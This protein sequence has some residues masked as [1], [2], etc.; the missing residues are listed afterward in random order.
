MSRRQD[1]K[2]G[3]VR[4]SAEDPQI[5]GDREL[6]T[7]LAPGERPRADPTLT[8][9]E[10]E[11]VVTTELRIRLAVVGI[12]LLSGIIAYVAMTGSSGALF[13]LV[14]PALLLLAAVVGG[15]FA[16]VLAPLGAR[17]SPVWLNDNLDDSLAPIRQEREV[18]ESKGDETAGQDDALRSIN[19]S[20]NRL[21]EYYTV[22]LAQAR[23][24]FRLSAFALVSG[25]L[26]IILGVG[27]LYVDNERVEVTAISAT[28][29]IIGEF[30]G[31]AYFYVYK[32]SLAQVNYFYQNLLRQGETALALSL[33]EQLET[34]KRDDA[35]VRLIEMLM[36]R[37]MLSAPDS[38]KPV[39]RTRQKPDDASGV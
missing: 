15:P 29:G 7:S 3:D 5:G 31:A 35:K 19:L 33:A 10:N 30:I 23:G 8:Q 38:S 9:E 36:T 13:A 28:A 2:N 16:T 34:S 26:V 1:Q 17:L 20:L 12:L 14:L 6:E 4:H 24:S 39:A 22:N 11:A 32:R 27:L 25:L 18:L 21:Q 37:E